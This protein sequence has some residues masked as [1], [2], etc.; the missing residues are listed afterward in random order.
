MHSKVIETSLGVEKAHDE[1]I[2]D[3]VAVEKLA[4]SKTY[5][6]SGAAGKTDP[7]EIALVRK[8]DWRIM[9]MLWAMYFMN[10]L[11]KQAIA[12]A[13]LN[14]LEDDIGLTGSEYNTCIS[15]LFVGYLLMQLPSN[16]LMASKRV[17]PSIYMGCCMAVWA[18]CSACTALV[19]NYRGLVI[20]R[21]FLGVAEAPFY[22]GALF[23]LSIFYTRK[24]IATRIA[25]LYSANILSTAFSGL[26]AAAIFSTIDGAHGVEGWR[27][28]FII[29][30]VVTFGIA[31]L[32]M[33]ALPDHPSS[34][35]WLSEGEMA[36]AQERIARDTVERTESQS[37]FQNLKVAFSDP[38]LYLLALM[39][40][41]HLSAAGFNNFFPTVVGT[42]GFDRT[43]TLVLTCPPFVFAA[44]FGPLLALSSGR[45]NERTWHITAGMAMGL[46]GFVIAAATLNTAARYLAC[47][48][49]S[50]GVYSVNS[51]ILGW[52]S[53]TL[54]QTAEKKAISLSF[55]NIM[56]NASY[57]YTPYLYP[58]SD[59]PRYLPAM[60]ANAGFAAGTVICAWG[61][62]IWLMAENKQLRAN[63]GDGGL[64]YAY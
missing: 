8:L 42:L 61:L 50:A 15:I 49:F 40:N 11:D 38:R 23:L 22:P 12:S 46:A 9:P 7:A 52:V 59:G 1:L 17:R 28:L 54:G 36:T 48:L 63:F 60:G 45:F 29:E 6:Y 57:I 53:A 32:S 39:Q 14:K 35:R 24:E 4:A 34:T 27:W 16:M 30:G 13:R 55:V 58:S 19:Q 5:D 51:C 37:S 18:V 21:F 3:E 43:I 44:V 64:A 2:D 33:W 25:I 62:K 10:Y 31:L 56:A 26:I 41:L 20:A 47:F